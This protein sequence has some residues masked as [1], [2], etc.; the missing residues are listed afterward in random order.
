M[1]PAMLHLENSFFVAQDD[2]MIVTTDMMA[3]VSLSILGEPIAQPRICFWMLA[4]VLHVIPY[5][6]A[7]TKKFAFQGV[8]LS[9]LADLGATAFP[10]FDSG[11]KLKVTATFHVFDTR[12]DIDNLVKFLL[13]SLETI[14]LKNDNMVYW[15]VGKKICM[16]KNME[17][18]KL[19]VKSIKG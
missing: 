19:E 2:A 5:D 10:L 3:T 9:A 16:T 12:K 4:G 15:L 13:D 1:L 18:M 7:H 8:V 17:F 11:E 14:A 6:P